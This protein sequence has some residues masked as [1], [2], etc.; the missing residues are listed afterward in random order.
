VLVKDYKRQL[1]GGT[2]VLDPVA[3]LKIGDGTRSRLPG[4]PRRPDGS[5]SRFHVLIA[6]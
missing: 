3:A 5:E 6:K 4:T 2:E 1:A